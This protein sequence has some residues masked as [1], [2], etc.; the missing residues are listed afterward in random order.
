MWIHDYITRSGFE[1]DAFVE[2]SLIGMYAK[3][4]SIDIVFFVLDKMLERDVVSWIA[5]NIGYVFI[6]NENEALMLLRQKKLA[7][8]IKID[9][10]TMVNV[11]TACA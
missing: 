10:V 11:L 9:Y 7:G 5:M 8:H 3:C 4:R 6:G 1:L 2:T